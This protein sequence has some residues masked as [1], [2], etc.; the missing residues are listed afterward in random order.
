MSFHRLAINTTRSKKEFAMRSNTNANDVRILRLFQKTTG[1][2]RSSLRESNIETLLF[3]EESYILH[4]LHGLSALH[5]QMI[6]IRQLNL[7]AKYHGFQFIFPA[8]SFRVYLRL[9][10]KDS[11]QCR[12][13]F[14]CVKPDCLIKNMVNDGYIKRSPLDRSYASSTS[15]M[16]FQHRLIWVVRTWTILYTI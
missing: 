16:I 1:G 15:F 12:A 4:A 14:L 7:S 10:W 11:T 6:R 5:T 13:L 8:I 3:Q 2:S 9:W